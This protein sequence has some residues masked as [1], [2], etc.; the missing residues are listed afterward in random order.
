VRLQ[1]AGPAAPT[2]RRGCGSRSDG[3]APNLKI[4]TCQSRSKCTELLKSMRPAG[5]RRPPAAATIAE[6]A[7]SSLRRQRRGVC[8]AVAMA[9]RVSSLRCRP[10][11]RAVFKS[12]RGRVM[13][14]ITRK[15]SRSTRSTSTDFYVLYALIASKILSSSGERSAIP[16]N[17]VFRK[18]FVYGHF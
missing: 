3:A 16:S 15:T 18:H 7:A 13:K 8:R 4:E 14:K 11:G 12:T 2:I 1:A 17:S 6:A 5:D 9:A 10:P